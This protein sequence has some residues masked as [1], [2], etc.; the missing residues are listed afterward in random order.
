MTATDNIMLRESLDAFHGEVA[1]RFRRVLKGLDSLKKKDGLYAWEHRRLIGM[2]R[3]V[4][5]VIEAHQDQ[6]EED[7]KKTLPPVDG[8]GVEILF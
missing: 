6:T 2:Y 7:K 4:L 5:S 8:H 3:D 1:T